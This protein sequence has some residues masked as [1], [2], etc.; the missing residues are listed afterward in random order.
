MSG[1][2]IVEVESSGSTAGIDPLLGDR[3]RERRRRVQVREHRCRRR[4]GEVVGRHVDRLDRGHRALLGRGDPLLQA[5]HLGLQRRL[6]ADRRG[7]PPEQR[8]DLGARLDEAE[9]VVD[10]QEHVLP[11]LLAEVLG[12]RQPGERDPQAGAGRLVHLAEDEHRLVED[13]RLL[14]LEPEVVA[15][16]RALADAAEGRKALVLLG[17]VSDQLLDQ[18]GLSDPGAAEQADLA[19]LGIGG[20]Q[21]DDLD[22]GLED[23]LRRG[24]VLDARRRPVDRPA[25]VR[26]DLGAVVDRLPE[27]VEDPAQRG[28]ADRD[29][30]RTAGVDHFVAALQA[31][32]GVHGDRSDS[33]VAEVLLNLAD[34]IHVRPVALTGDLDLER[35]VDLGQLLVEDRIDHDAGH[36]LDP[37]DVGWV[38]VALSHR[39]PSLLSRAP[40]RRRLPPRFPA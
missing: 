33:I 18:H 34:Q 15:L 5:A 27:Q 2:R 6:V 14:H 22:P 8:R 12:H 26:L 3:P 7:H 39:S 21:V 16:A 35:R 11:A 30:D 10:E 32:G 23:L 36:R 9:D 19:A 37:A 20:E 28:A 24:Q 29:R 13:S 17:Q 40:R 4:V 31:V 1:F 38:S 25:V